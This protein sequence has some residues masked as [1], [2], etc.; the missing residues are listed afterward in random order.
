[1]LKYFFV[2][3]NTTEFKLGGLQ[4]DVVLQNLLGREVT[5]VL[6]TKVGKISAANKVPPTLTPKV[7]EENIP[8]DEDDEKIQCESA[9]VDLSK[10][11][12]K[13]AK[14]DPEEILQ[15]VHLSGITDWNPAEQHE[16]HNLICKYACIFSQNDLDLGKTLIV[17]HLI[18]LMD[19]TPFKEHYWCI[20]PRMYEEWRHI[21]KKCLI[22]VLFIH[23][24]AHGK[25]LWS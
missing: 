21:Y 24:I 15:K 2:S 16:A 18:K 19:S 23:Q 6:H 17:K 20:P 13:Q 9:Q 14:V 11:K 12:A 7:I 25:V 1:M 4:V 3:G 22:Y 8:D 5:L 10:S